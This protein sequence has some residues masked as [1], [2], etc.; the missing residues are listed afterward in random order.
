MTTE[1]QFT[2]I[3]VP[4]MKPDAIDNHVVA[5]ANIRAT[6]K[7]VK[8]KTLFTLHS[9]SRCVLCGISP[10]DSKDKCEY[11]N[12]FGSAFIFPSQT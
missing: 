6:Q 5:T 12:Q 8:D 4:V 2:V 10:A 11:F 9:V 7:W 3:S 1:V